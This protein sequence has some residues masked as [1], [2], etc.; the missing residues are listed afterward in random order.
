MGRVMKLIAELCQNHNGKMPVLKKMVELAAES[1]ADIC[2]IQSIKSR[3]LIYWKEFEDF[4]PYEKEYERLK[5]LELSV[6]DERKFFDYCTENGVKPMTTI[7]NGRDFERF[8]KVGYDD[9]KLSGYSVGKILPF[10]EQF[11]FRRLYISTSSLSLEQIKRTKMIL[12]KKNIK[13]YTFLNCTCV[14]PTP[15]DKLNLQNIDFFKNELEIKKVG[16][17]DHSNPYED[18]L[19]S[20]KL[21]IYQGIDT[22]ERHFTILK[23]E[24]TRDGKV[25]ITPNMVRELKRFSKLTKTQQYEEL[26]EFNETQKFNH[27]YYRNRF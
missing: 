7:F 16:F 13:D 14:Y 20:S 4:R 10:I 3:D 25:S 12:D 9:L 24:D 11:N 1:G 27:H 6:D 26:N 15:L 2:K 21:A 8:N 23:P 5:S 18:N 22:L 19:L 17:S